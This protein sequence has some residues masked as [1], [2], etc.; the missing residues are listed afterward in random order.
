MVLFCVKWF[1]RRPSSR[2]NRAK[3]KEMIDEY[4]SEHDEEY[5]VCGFMNESSNLTT[6]QNY[7]SNI[8]FNFDNRLYLAVYNDVFVLIFPDITLNI[9]VL[10]SLYERTDIKS[11][12]EMGF[13]YDIRCYLT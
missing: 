9:A 4:T 7:S 12:E 6:N 1:G 10:I 11:Y 13:A 8:L 5:I 2:S 3:I